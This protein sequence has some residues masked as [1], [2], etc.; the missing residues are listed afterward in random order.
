VPFLNSVDDAGLINIFNGVDDAIGSIR[1]EVNVASQV[2]L[3]KID[4][5]LAGLGHTGCHH[6]DFTFAA[7]QLI[8]EVRKTRIDVSQFDVQV[9]GQR[10]RHIDVETLQLTGQWI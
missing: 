4:T 10:F 1:N 6:G 9:L 5:L 3:R 8:Y 7:V 2:R